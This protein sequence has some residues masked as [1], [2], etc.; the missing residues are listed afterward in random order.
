MKLLFLIFKKI[1]KFIFVSI[2]LLTLIFT[3][4]I[5]SLYLYGLKEGEKRVLLKNYSPSL[6]FVDRNSDYLF[7]Y[8]N[9]KGLLGFWEI[10]GQIPK[11]IKQAI[12]SAED[13][14]FYTDKGV[15]FKALFRSAYINIIT[16]KKASGASSIA[17]QVVRM[18][19]P[20][21]RNYLNKLVEIFASLKLV[22]KYGYEKIL[23]HYLT[24]APFGL[25]YHGIVFASLKYF[26]KPINDLSIAESAI[27]AAIPKSPY[28]YNLYT[29]AGKTH[30]INRAKMILNLMR[31]NNFI[32]DYQLECSLKEL[33]QLPNFYYEEINDINIHYI[34][35][36]K[37]DI[38][39]NKLKFNNYLI[40]TSIDLN[41]QK[42][43]GDKAFEFIDSIKNDGGKNCAIIVADKKNGDIISYIG[44]NYYFDKAHKGKIDYAN[45][46]RSSGSTLKPFLY[47]YGMMEKG[48][49]GATILSDIGVSYISDESLYKPEN[50][51]F[52]FEGPVLYRYA[53]ANSRNIPAIQI[54]NEIGVQKTYDFFKYIGIERGNKGGE[55]YGLNLAIGGLYVTLYDLV[56][57]YGMLANDGKE[58]KLNF[59]LDE[60]KNRKYSKQIIPEDIAE[61]I[62]LFLS[63][64]NARVPSFPRK[65]SLEYPFPVAIKTGTSQGFR[66]AWTICYSEKYVVG[67]WVGDPDNNKMKNLTGYNS[68][69]KLL[70]NV[71][72]LIH[73]KD[74]I[75]KNNIS[76]PPP[77]EYIPKEICK[78]TGKLANQYSK[79]T[80][81]E[82]FKQGTEPLEQSNLYQEISINR[83]T[84]QYA[85]PDCPPKLIE[86]RMVTFIP[87]KYGDWAKMN[88]LIMA[89]VSSS[90]IGREIPASLDDYKIELIEP[91]NSMKYYINPSIS[92]DF[93]SI[94]LKAIIDPPVEQA[95]WYIDDKPYQV[96]DFPYSTRWTLKRG[97]HTIQLKFTYSQFESEKIEIIVE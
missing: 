97:V 94:P 10:Q 67:V 48:Y 83:E 40:K 44:S 78:I 93:Q 49:T 35:R 45:T 81:T 71:M 4:I 18:E 39:K 85:T 52:N 37:E 43:L 69:G 64:P 1:F 89:P 16:K 5:A 75:E 65:S 70:R 42:N 32:S 21:P 51:D 46:P 90:L 9:N 3:P 82:W 53:L 34:N 56:K 8:E 79:E 58:F 57:C 15:D 61:M 11:N 66:D 54:L 47:A 96:V 6:Y 2:L 62:T 84:G 77:K 29:V 91:I 30:T 28:K 41:I 13:K 17:M 76:F 74:F 72:E 26:K 27:L 73:E 25:R 20:Y 87:P 24:I 22:K 80:V 23:K 50:N 88:G 7:D 14:N 31:K 95:I 12:I 68:A 92:I 63:D 36:I 38:T 33:N 59:L 19:Y 60:E 86:K 55:Y